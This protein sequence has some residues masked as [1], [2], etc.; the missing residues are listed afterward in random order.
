M[1]DNIPEKADFEKALHAWFLE[2]ES[3]MGQDSTRRLVK[4]SLFSFRV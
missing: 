2:A 3:M 4:I 1:A